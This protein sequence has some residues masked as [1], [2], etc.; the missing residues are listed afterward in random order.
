MIADNRAT[1]IVRVNTANDHQPAHMAKPRVE[2]KLFAITTWDEQRIN[3][4]IT[5]AVNAGEL[6]AW[7]EPGDNGTTRIWLCAT[8]EEHI[9]ALIGAE[10]A[11]DNPDTDLIEAAAEYL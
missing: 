11:K 9:R 4:E 5:K 10:N 1:N 3:Q 8:D 2:A 6:F 7:R